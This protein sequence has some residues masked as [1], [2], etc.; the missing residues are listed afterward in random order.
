MKTETQLDKDWLD[1]P[2]IVRGLYEGILER[3]ADKAGFDSHL[4]AL[5]DGASLEK[6]IRGMIDSDEFK[7]RHPLKTGRDF[8]P[9]L[10]ENYASKYVRKDGDFSLFQVSSDGDFDLLEGLIERHRFYDSNDVYSPVID[11]DKRVTAAIVGGLGA[12]SC[13]E[14]GCFSGPVL[15]VLA[16]QGIDV[17]GTDVSHLAFVLAYANIRE[18]LRFGDLLNLKFDRTYDV[19]FAMDVLEHL[20]PLSLDRYIHTIARM[21]PR[22]GFVFINSPM[23]G[24]DDVFGTA[25]DAYLP[26]WR[27][28]GDREYWRHIHCDGKGW[29]VHGH[30]IFASPKWWE[31]SFLKHG[32][33]RDRDIERRIHSLLKTFFEKVAPARRSFFVLKHT[34][35]AHDSSVVARNLEAAIA[36]V[37]ANI[38]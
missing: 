4:A 2:K 34:D 6:L 12:R 18:K 7:V 10:T 31:A 33:V 24:D 27:Q 16:E 19:F 3:P 38:R 30:L 5:K 32:L 8:L 13:I 25:S 23:F 11:L 17:C 20:N 26:E 37:V 1:F 36:P 29:P 28:A 14:M 21:V 9:D 35:A 22:N 15:S